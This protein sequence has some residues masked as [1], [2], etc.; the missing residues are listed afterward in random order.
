MNTQTPET[1]AAFEVELD[2]LNVTSG[3]ELARKLERERD[4]A[5]NQ[6]FRICR[7]G[8]DMHDTIGLEPADDYVLRKLADMQGA[9]IAPKYSEYSLATRP[10]NGWPA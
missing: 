9:H 7:E 6:L 4:E 8:F 5:R 3:W 1:D 10:A 2:N